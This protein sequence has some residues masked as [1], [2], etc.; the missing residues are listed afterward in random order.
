MPIVAGDRFNRSIDWMQ[1]NLF[2]RNRVDTCLYL[3]ACE[4]SASNSEQ[5]CRL[6]CPGVVISGHWR[7]HF[8]NLVTLSAISEYFI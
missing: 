6:I 7:E 5:G 4:F 2:D 3:N 1:I 8:V